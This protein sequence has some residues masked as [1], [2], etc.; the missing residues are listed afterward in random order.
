MYRTYIKRVLDI[1]LSLLALIVLGPVFAVV[2]LMV[3]IKLGKPVLFRQTRPGKDEKLFRIFK[4]RT[5]TDQ[6]DQY[7]DLLPDIQRLPRFGRILRST[8]LDELPE[9]INILTG[10]MSFVGPRP[11]AV[12]YLPYYSETE[13]HRHDVRPGLTGLAQINGR[14]ALQWEKRFGYDVYYVEH[15]SFFLDVKIMIQ[16]FFKVFRQED[17]VPLGEGI[18]EDFNTYRERQKK[19][20]KAEE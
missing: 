5:M 12:E 3:R 19:S 18:E 4:F 10:D 15:L 13:R 9:L 6:R 20:G 17:V 16:T 14:N 2:A 8:S 11:L 7:G 1:V